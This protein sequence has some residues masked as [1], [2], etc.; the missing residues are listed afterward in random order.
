MTCIAFCFR[1]TATSVPRLRRLAHW[2]LLLYFERASE[3]RVGSVRVCSVMCMYMSKGSWAMMKCGE[4][5][6]SRKCVAFYMYRCVCTVLK[7]G[8]APHIHIYIYTSL[9]TWKPDTQY[10]AWCCSVHP[11]GSP[12]FSCVLRFLRRVE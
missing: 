3:K 4:E 2:P 9:L 7:V 8:T 12:S 6:N 11:L 10:P 5:E 1:F